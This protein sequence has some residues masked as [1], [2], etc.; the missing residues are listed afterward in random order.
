M[1][2]GDR[3]GHGL[4]LGTDVKSYYAIRRG[5]VYLPRQVLLDNIAWI[6]HEGD[7]KGTADK[8]YRDLTDLYYSLVME[9]YRIKPL[10]DD[11]FQSICLRGDNPCIG[12]GS[13][14]QV[15]RW[16]QLDENDDELAVSARTNNDAIQLYH[17][18]HYDPDVVSRGNSVREFRVDD[19]FIEVIQSVR[20]RMLHL[21]EERGIA[22]ETNP[23]SNIKIGHMSTY[24]THPLMEF[25]NVG[26]NTTGQYRGIS[27]SI[28]TD[29][30]GVFGTSL[31]REFSLVATALEKEYKKGKSDIPPRVIY[32]WLDKIRQMA[33]EQ[34]FNTTSFPDNKAFHQASHTISDNPKPSSLSLP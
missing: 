10:L 31:E 11:Y 18:Y 8:L 7:F 12:K 22:I 14:R 25:N 29:D 28:N 33:F 23:T 20:M 2:R 26:L 3:I 19:A 4:V 5:L 13:V 32:D 27:V 17:Q 21:I 34:V 6:L 9:I 1:T 24:N 30:S 16:N 15:T